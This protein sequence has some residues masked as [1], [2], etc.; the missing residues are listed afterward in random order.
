MK[1]YTLIITAV[2]IGICSA[3]AA[4]QTAASVLDAVRARLSA[5]PATDATFSIASPSGPIHGSVTMSGNKYFMATP[6][7]MAWYDGKTQWV[8]VLPS[9]EVTVTEPTRAEV[10]SSNPFA[11]LSDYR[12]G[13]RIRRLKDASGLRRVELTPT[14]VTSSIKTI[15]IHVD[16]ASNYPRALTVTFDDNRIMHVTIDTMTAAQG[17]PTAT[18]SYD[19]KRYPASEIIDL[20]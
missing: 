5:T 13:Y 2:L 4:G 7:M 18:F 16:P 12:S 17:R 20:R 3:W 9:R 15:V 8:M 10:L 11:I 6:Q 1:R 14:D 19:A